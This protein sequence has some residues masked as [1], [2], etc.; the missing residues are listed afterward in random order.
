MNNKKP[1]FYDFDKRGVRAFV[2]YSIGTGAWKI[3]FYRRKTK[4]ESKGENDWEMIRIGY[5]GTFG[6]RIEAETKALE[7]AE[8]ICK[9]FN[10]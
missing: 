4:D 7:Q 3:E 10:F 8:I 5:L 9:E 6:S 1:N 2:L